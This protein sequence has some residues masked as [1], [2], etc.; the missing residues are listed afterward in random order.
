MPLPSDPRPRGVNTANQ[1]TTC[2]L[3]RPT[4]AALHELKRRTG[5]GLD[6]IVYAL[7]SEALET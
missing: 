6:A 4:L 5:L 1:P 7:A 2:R 3:S